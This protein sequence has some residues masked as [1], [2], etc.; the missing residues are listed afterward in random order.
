MT[1]FTFAK[2]RAALSV[3]L[4]DL[5]L[6]LVLSSTKRARRSCV[7]LRRSA[8]QITD[9]LHS[10]ALHAT[11]FFLFDLGDCRKLFETSQLF[12]LIMEVVAKRGFGAFWWWLYTARFSC[13]LR[14]RWKNLGDRFGHSRNTMKGTLACSD[15]ETCDFWRRKGAKAAI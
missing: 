12:D 3:M 6:L 13:I 8:E 9:A 2:H 4:V 5:H 1:A 10:T 15:R 14:D 7:V 11:G